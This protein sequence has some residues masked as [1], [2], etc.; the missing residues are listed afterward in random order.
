MN[1]FGQLDEAGSSCSDKLMDS[2]DVNVNVSALSS[3]VKEFVK[4]KGERRF[5]LE[6]FWIV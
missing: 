4:S 1:K 3:S 6:F 5:Y 2:V